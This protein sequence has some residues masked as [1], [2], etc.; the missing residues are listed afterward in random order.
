MR[1]FGARDRIDRGKESEMQAQ[2][3]HQPPCMVAHDMINKFA[4][5][6]GQCDLQQEKAGLG[7]EYVGWINRIRNLAAKAVEDLKEHQSQV[8]RETSKSQRREA[9]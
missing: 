8:S 9:G 3:R 2:E 1:K 6:I 4:A 7:A 5:I